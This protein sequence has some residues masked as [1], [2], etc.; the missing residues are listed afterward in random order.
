MEKVH[1]VGRPNSHKSNIEMKV[2]LPLLPSWLE[3]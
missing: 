2:E 1:A 3:R